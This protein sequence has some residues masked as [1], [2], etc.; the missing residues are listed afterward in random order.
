MCLCAAVRAAGVIREYQRVE[1]ASAVPP[2]FRFVGGLDLQPE[3]GRRAAQPAA[4]RR[5]DGR[6]AKP[7]PVTARRRAKAL[8]HRPSVS[9]RAPRAR[10]PRVVRPRVARPC[11]T[12]RA[13]HVRASA[14]ARLSLACA[15]RACRSSRRRTSCGTCLSGASVARALGKRARALLQ[16]ALQYARVQR[17]GAR[18]LAAR[19]GARDA[20]ACSGQQRA[21]R[22]GTQRAVVRGAWRLAAPGGAWRATACSARRR[23]APRAAAARCCYTSRCVSAFSPTRP[24]RLARP[25]PFCSYPVQ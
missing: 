19:G 22:G 15:V 16:Y 25:R 20:A 13:L 18:R 17:A 8:I 11:A 5:A 14:R 1:G 4:G 10:R 24:R 21:A 6:G 3:N 2:D 12:P 9:R 23:A 7:S